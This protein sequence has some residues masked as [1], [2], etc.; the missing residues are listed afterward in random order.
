MWLNVTFA[1]GFAESNGEWLDF[2]L[3]RPL[4]SIFQTPHTN[5]PN[6]RRNSVSVSN[7]GSQDGHARRYEMPCHF[8]SRYCWNHLHIKFIEYFHICS[9]RYLMLSFQFGVFCVRDEKIVKERKKKHSWTTLILFIVIVFKS[10]KTQRERS[11]KR[12]KGEEKS[13]R[14]SEWVRE[15]THTQ[16]NIYDSVFYSLNT[17]FLRLFHSFFLSFCI[18]FFTSI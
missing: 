10:P 17:F 12:S 6:K 4:K 9:V 5:E 7:N 13:D 2:Y 15:N 14:P 11:D 3:F 16:K 18:I 8:F 1:F